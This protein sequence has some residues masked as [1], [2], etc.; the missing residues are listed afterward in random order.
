M[1]ALTL[2]LIALLLWPVVALAAF[3]CPMYVD[4]QVNPYGLCGDCHAPYN[5]APFNC[6]V[7][8]QANGY[9]GCSCQDGSNAIGCANP[10][11]IRCGGVQP[12]C[13]ALDICVG[14]TVLT[15]L[16]LAGTGPA[17][18][19]DC[20]IPGT[21][22][23]NPLACTCY[24]VTLKRALSPEEKALHIKASN[25]LAA[26]AAAALLIIVAPPSVPVSL[27]FMWSTASSILAAAALKAQAI[28][29]DP[30]LPSYTTITHPEDVGLV[31]PV[32]TTGDGLRPAQVDALNAASR[33]F[34]E[35]QAGEQAAK[36]SLFRASG[37][38][39]G[40]SIYWYHQ[41]LDA[42]DYAMTY[43]QARYAMM[44]TTMPAFCTSLIWAAKPANGTYPATIDYRPLY[45]ASGICDGGLAQT[46][47][48]LSVED[49]RSQR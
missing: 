15:C 41:Q 5:P 46:M 35:I 42:F 10:N 40:A 48:K 11:L 45:Q 43:L 44:A 24:L 18:A 23:V 12:W 14:N 26:F 28:A 25:T 7:T 17:Y 19:P 9:L 22:L 1:K 34:T 16:N 36:Q 8:L 2:A 33:L 3:T 6:G 4:P 37:A 27:A 20:M 31:P 30:P 49:L 39:D 38:Q 21:N 47:L 29:N 32:V 13:S